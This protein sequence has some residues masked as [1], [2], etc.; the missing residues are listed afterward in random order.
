MKPDSNIKIQVHYIGSGKPFKTE[1]EPTTTVG[2]VKAAALAAFGFVED[3]TKT[4][5][6]FL[7]G[8]E[9]TNTNQTVGEAAGQHRDLNLNL[10]EFLVQGVS[11]SYGR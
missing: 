9:L 2:Q 10:E 1:V 11:T 7:Q 6:L 5:K 8:T 4:Y 3:T